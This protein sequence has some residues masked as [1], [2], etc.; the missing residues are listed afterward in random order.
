[1]GNPADEFRRHMED[2]PPAHEG[3]WCPACAK[4]VIPAEDWSCPACGHNPGSA[5]LLERLR[6]AKG[7]K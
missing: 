2:A 4:L 1:M 6:L 5:K 7:G 3:V